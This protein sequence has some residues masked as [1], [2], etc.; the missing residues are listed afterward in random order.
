MDHAAVSRARHVR[1]MLAWGFWLFNIVVIVAFWWLNSG[2][3]F[4]GDSLGDAIIA[5]GRLAGLLAT[6]CALTQFV[7]M[8][9]AGW[10]EPI[11]GMDR[12]ALFH[13]YNGFATLLFIFA[14]TGLIG[15]GY[16]VLNDINIT[17]QFVKLVTADV[18]MWMA[19]T[20]EMLFVAV[21]GVSMYIVRKHLKFETWY[22]VHI[23]VYA[24]I[25]LVPWHQLTF[26]S[27]LV[28][29]P[30]FRYY[31]IGLYAFAAL[32]LLIWRFGRIGWRYAVH[33]F[34]VE[35]IVPETATATSVYITG[36][37][38]DKFKMRGGQFVLVRFL[39]P[40]LFLQ[41]HPFSLSMV[42]TGEH[43]RLTIRQLGD[44]TNAV[45]HIKPGTPVL[46]SGPHGAFTHEKQLTNK[47]L[48]IAGGVGITP[49]RSLI[50]ERAGW[51][52]TEDAVF[53][54]GNRTLDDTIF[55]KELADLAKKLHMPMHNVLSE[56]KNYAGEKGYIDK[57]KIARLVPDVAT[58]DVYLCGP[59]PMMDGIRAA[60]AELGVPK[61]QVHYER[62]SLYKK[63]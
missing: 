42:P 1:V 21:V 35:K 40:E 55:P 43:L 39:S 27:D 63:G 30:L 48:Y 47:V 36:K 9:R 62:F 14:H 17:E 32:N 61:A 50:A 22:A 57:E 56:E 52:N 16:S 11:F 4:L 10:L 19:L 38:L 24:A 60:L 18:V 15:A 34:R 20:A 37:H 12:I 26:G 46:I 5:A 6:F 54:Y 8:G 29:D 3:I 33:K 59:P 25:A 44:F 58:R 2:S 31:W 49:I 51:T 28:S 45:P 23:M 41:E 13:R 7:L 53:L